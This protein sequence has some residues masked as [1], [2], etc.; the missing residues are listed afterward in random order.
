MR[1]VPTREAI[2]LTGLSG[3]KLREW[4]SR[5]A[6]IPA[7]IPPKSQ[8]SSAQYSWQTILLLRL[9]AELR[10]RFHLEL[11]V[12]RSL[13]ASLRRS[14]HGKS[15]VVLW[16]K[17]LALYGGEHWSLINAEERS[18]AAEDALLIRLDPHLGILAAGFEL[19]HPSGASRQLDLFPAL[20]V[21]AS[22]IPAAA[23]RSPT[24]SSAMPLV[25]RRRTG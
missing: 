1:L 13:F 12:H 11:Q 2:R 24:A 21:S 4:T 17:T 23:I 5:R 10:S 18:D 3:P 25:R 15:F 6:L 9:A 14:F 8:G 16:G 7:D 20:A 19:P 22:H